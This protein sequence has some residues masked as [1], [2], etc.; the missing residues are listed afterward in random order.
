MTY[1][2]NIVQQVNVPS[3]SCCRPPVKTPKSKRGGKGVWQIQTSVK[4]NV[5]WQMTEKE[6]REKQL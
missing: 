1:L 3:K 6:I 5:C 2:P 4:I